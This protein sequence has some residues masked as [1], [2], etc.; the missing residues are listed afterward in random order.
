MVVAGE[1]AD[2]DDGGPQMM[3]TEN[4]PTLEKQRDESDSDFSD[5]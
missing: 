4:L 3:M 1:A 5:L 2:G